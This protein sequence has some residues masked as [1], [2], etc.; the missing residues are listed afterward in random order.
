MKV[1]GAT[2]TAWSLIADAFSARNHMTEFAPYSNG[3]SSDASLCN[4]WDAKATSS[5]VSWYLG[6]YVMNFKGKGVYSLT[7]SK[8]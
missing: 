1:N 5:E 4:Y 6:G 7:Y 3:T 2:N 8:S